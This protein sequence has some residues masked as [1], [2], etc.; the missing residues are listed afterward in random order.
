MRSFSTSRLL[1]NLFRRGFPACRVLALT[2]APT[3]PIPPPLRHHRS[4]QAPQGALLLAIRHPSEHLFLYTKAALP[5]HFRSSVLG[6]VTFSQHPL[7]GII[8]CP[9]ANQDQ[10]K[11]QHRNAINF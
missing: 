11:K 4:A 1:L 10:T 9:L 2:N 6:F 3:E 7:Q 8:S 5:Q